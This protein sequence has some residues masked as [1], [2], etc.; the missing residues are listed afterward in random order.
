MLDNTKKKKYLLV[1]ALGTEVVVD[2]TALLVLGDV[3][4]GLV[5]VGLDKGE[6][7]GVGVLG[8]VLQLLG[9]GLGDGS[10]GGLDTSLE[11]EEDELAQ[12]LLQAE[13]V[14]GKSL[15]GVVAATVVH[16]NSNGACVPG[17]HAA[18]LKLLKGESVKGGGLKWG[19]NEIK[20]WKMN[21]K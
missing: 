4:G 8:H 11:G 18:G 20:V 1:T 16:G 2:E 10:L 15:V 6:H 17:G 19:K 21:R 13:G 14:L 3:T 7:L 5:G 12:V 9:G